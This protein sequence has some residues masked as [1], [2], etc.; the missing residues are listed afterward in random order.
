MSEF[1]IY[2]NN[3]NGDYAWSLF[4]KMNY[5]NKEKSKNDYHMQSNFDDSPFY[6][7]YNFEENKS[8]S[9][10][11]QYNY[12]NT[13]PWNQIKRE[14]EYEFR[15]KDVEDEHHLE[16]TKCEQHYKLE[17]KK[18]EIQYERLKNEVETKFR[19]IQIRLSSI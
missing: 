13:L 6:K 9:I 2:T 10:Q 19:I 16:S 7:N 15:K 4:K 8:N 12:E 5:L 11:K 3:D 17:L 14:T 1:T 18:I